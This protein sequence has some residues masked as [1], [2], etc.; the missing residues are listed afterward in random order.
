MA[1]PRKVTVYCES[2]LTS[3]AANDLAAGAFGTVVLPYHDAGDDMLR[4]NIQRMNGKS[5][6]F[7]IRR[8]CE[9]RSVDS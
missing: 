6:L 1:D 3:S 7:S 5:V 9:P 4:Q 8:R 2:Y